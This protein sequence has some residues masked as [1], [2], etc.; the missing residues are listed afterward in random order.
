[1]RT[2]YTC[3]LYRVTTCKS[4][5]AIYIC[6]NV[7][8][9]TCG[10]ADQEQSTILSLIYLDE[11]IGLHA[12]AVGRIWRLSPSQP[13]WND[14]DVLTPSE[15]IAWYALCDSCIGNSD[16]SSHIMMTPNASYDLSGTY[17]LPCKIFEI[18]WAN[19]LPAQLASTLPLARLSR[20]LG[21]VV[22]CRVDFTI[23]GSD[24]VAIR[25]NELL[26]REKAHP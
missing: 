13:A 24:V 7:L 17:I 22:H 15:N 19:F 1:M 6:D 9:Y 2:G 25:G 18:L 16:C 23:G 20:C 12:K 21:R 14:L 8:L 3:G 4:Y 10:L 26:L 5:S 11:K